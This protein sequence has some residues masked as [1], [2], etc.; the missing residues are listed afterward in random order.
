LRL[1]LDAN[2]LDPVKD[3]DGNAL[4]GEW[5]NNSSTFSSGNGT[6]GGDFEFTFNVL[7]ADID[8][9]GL[10]TYYDYF[11]VNLLSGK[12]TTSQGYIALRDLDGSGLIDSTDT[13]AVSSRYVNSLPSGT[14]AGASNDAP[15]TSGF[16]LT[17]INDAAVDVAISL[18]SRFGDAESGA[19]GMTYSIRSN[20][21]PS[22]FDDVHVNSLTGELILNAAASVSGRSQIVVRATDPGGLFVEAT[23]TIDVNRTNQAPVIAPLWISSLGNGL[24]LFEGHV[25]DADDDVSEF[26]LYYY[27]YYVTQSGVDENGDF[28][29]VIYVEPNEWGWENLTT[30]DL[31]GLQS[32]IT[33]G[34]VGLT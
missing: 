24:Y 17:Q 27:G 23:A 34:W 4:D 1:D 12:S 7:P 26:T 6:A 33:G 21:A 13:Q 19:S 28:A 3:L 15:T 31:H 32:N 11:Y 18:L 8:N 9:T 10:V 25:T 16:A 14:P 29:I 30:Y 20:S 2:G 22:L 5:T